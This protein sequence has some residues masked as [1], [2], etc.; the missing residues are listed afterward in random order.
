MTDNHGPNGKAAT[1]TAAESMDRLA[2]ELDGVRRTHEG[3]AVRYA[4]GGVVFAAREGGRLSFRLRPE[5]VE[6]ALRTPDTSL[7]ARGLQWI[8]LSPTV[9]DSFTLDRAAA[10]FESAWRLAGES[11][12][13]GAPLH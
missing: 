6:A 8:T 7:S 1:E 9:E 13:G 2:A 4:R 11:S 5:V 10:W 3:G 12:A